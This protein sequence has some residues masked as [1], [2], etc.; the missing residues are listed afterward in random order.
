MFKVRA[1]KGR[2][3]A[4]LLVSSVC[5]VSGC[6]KPTGDVSGQVSYKGKALEYGSVTISCAD[7]SMSGGEINPDGTYLVK[8]VPIGKGRVAV[9]AIDPKKIEANRQ[10]VKEMKDSQKPNPGRPNFDPKTYDSIPTKYGDPTTSGLELD[11][12]TG[13]NEFNIP[14][15]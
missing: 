3:I 15:N 14:L 12:K 11:V 10:A 4:V 6:G 13:K 1:M 7:G 5:L 2:A 8:G 9:T